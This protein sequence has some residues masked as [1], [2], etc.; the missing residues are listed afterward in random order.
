MALALRII[1]Q[2]GGTPIILT[3]LREQAFTMLLFTTSSRPTSLIQFTLITP[4]IR[5][6]AK[7]SPL[8]CGQAT[9][10]LPP[11]SLMAI[12]TFFFS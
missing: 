3:P 8:T 7:K 6:A 5:E 1:R 10:A 11:S 12:G 2:A 9:K 4:K